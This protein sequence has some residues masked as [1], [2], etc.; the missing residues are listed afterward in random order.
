MTHCPCGRFLPSTGVC[1]R[2]DETPEFTR[3]AG[4][5]TAR[6]EALLT[7]RPPTVAELLA[8]HPRGEGEGK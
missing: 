2:C 6:I 7:R 8:A 1:A 5:H 4:S 3:V